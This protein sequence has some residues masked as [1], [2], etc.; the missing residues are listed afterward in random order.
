MNQV[1]CVCSTLTPPQ[2]LLYQIFL[3][4]TCPHYPDQQ[5]HSFL[6]TAAPA[7]SEQSHNPQGFYPVAQRNCFQIK[8]WE[9]RGFC[10][11]SPGL[12]WSYTTAQASSQ[13][14][15]KYF[16]WLY[17]MPLLTCPGAYW[18]CLRLDFPFLLFPAMSPARIVQYSCL[19]KSTTS[20]H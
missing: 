18:V 15:K 19:C 2:F 12:P 13:M 14:L 5:T 4:F 7:C 16:W 20:L 17:L 6:L 9:Q 1:W 10:L 8:I 11:M 3:P